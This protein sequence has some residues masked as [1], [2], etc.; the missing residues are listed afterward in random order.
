[1][2]RSPTPR[3]DDAFISSISSAPL[4]TGAASLY[5][6]LVMWPSLHVKPFTDAP[7]MGRPEV[8]LAIDEVAEAPDEVDQAVSDVAPADDAPLGDAPHEGV[9]HDGVPPDGALPYG[10]PLPGL[11]Q[12]AVA[13]RTVEDVVR[14]ITLLEGSPEHA[15]TTADALHAVGVDRSVEDLA[16]LVTLLTESPRDTAS[17]DEAIRIAAERRPLDDVSRL[18]QL[19]HSTS[20]GPYCGQAA[21]RAVAV[22]RPVEELHELI[23]RLAADRTVR[24][25]PGTPL[26]ADLP[27]AV[28]SGADAASAC[29]PDAVPLTTQTV[30]A[31]D[32][33]AAATTGG[34]AERAEGHQNE[35]LRDED[36]RKEEAR[37]EE[38]P[39]EAGRAEEERTEEGRTED[40]SAK[41]RSP[42][43]ERAAERHP[44]KQRSV[45]DR[46]VKDRLARACSVDDRNRD[47]RRAAA[48]LWGTRGAALLV[49]L[50][51][52]AHAPRQW[53]GASHGVLAGT[54]LAAGLCGLLAFVLPVRTAPARLVAATAAFGVTAA[55]GVG[56]LLGGR[57]GLPDAHRLW[58]ATLAPPWLAAT[59]AAAAALMA[60]T[61]LLGALFTRDARR[62][63]AG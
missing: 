23:G 4:P 19:L 50:C 15:R 30:S 41:E 20:V 38:G 59:A 7:H 25:A 14:L 2:T 12:A 31:F 40:R 3:P 51:G 48:L 46:F 42:V 63:G 13:H 49:L 21:V 28:P 22:S 35:D 11:V 24:E 56:Q 36:R 54:V 1:M 26:S 47:G 5:P 29:P 6:H 27:T 10:D 16:R 9:P 18:M 37:K 34:T 61:V 39:T 55:L 32:A 33:W 52:A 53:A 44:P 8:P 57:F 58:D 17:A 60:L 62:E 43:K 45:K